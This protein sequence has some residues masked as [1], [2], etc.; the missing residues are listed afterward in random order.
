MI[1]EIDFKAISKD[2]NNWVFGF[3]AVEP[4]DGAVMLVPT[5][6][7]YDGQDMLLEVDI[8]DETAGQYIGKHD[9]NGKKI[10]E[11]DIC[12]IMI[13]GDEDKVYPPEALLAVIE[14]KKGSW[15][16]RPLFPELVHKDVREWK[17]FI[18]ANGD[19]WSEEY[20]EDIGNVF[21]NFKSE[22]GKKRLTE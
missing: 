1:R 13:L 7:V 11:H 2:T 12:K 10:Y 20:F 14:C 18:K 21:D 4:E 15:G 19:E 17:S 16:F 8:I 22:R 9:K 5:K 6:D 3:Y